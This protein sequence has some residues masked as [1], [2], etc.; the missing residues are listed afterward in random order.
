MSKCLWYS[1]LVLKLVCVP[2]CCD[3]IPCGLMSF[4]IHDDLETFW[5]TLRDLEGPWE[6]LRDLR[7]P[8]ETW[9]TVWKNLRNLE[10]TWE[11]VFERT[12]ETLRELERLWGNWRD[13]MRDLEGTSWNQWVMVL[14]KNRSIFG[15][16]QFAGSK[17]LKH[18]ESWEW[19]C[20]SSRW[21]E[22][23]LPYV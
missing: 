18:S 6:T 9:G 14:L 20:P 7:D 1:A 10:G 4:L 12:W 19:F 22:V 13:Y 17:S 2:S 15:R 23:P 8:E 16:L 5:G 3:V 21:R 11:T